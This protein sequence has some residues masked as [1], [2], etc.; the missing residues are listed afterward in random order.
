MNATAPQTS[1]IRAG[2]AMDVKT[3]FDIYKPA[4]AA[5]PEHEAF[6]T[7]GTRGHGRNAAVVA[8]LQ[9]QCRLASGNFPGLSFRVSFVRRYFGLAL[10]L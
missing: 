5:K 8:P 4:R 9:I 6:R 2:V 7:T 3:E 10:H 1:Q